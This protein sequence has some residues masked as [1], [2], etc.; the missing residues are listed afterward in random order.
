MRSWKWR[1]WTQLNMIQVQSA[2]RTMQAAAR[3]VLIRYCVARA[4][5]ASA[6]TLEEPSMNDKPLNPDHEH[7]PAYKSLDS[8]HTTTTDVDHPHSAV[9][10]KRL[11]TPILDMHGL[12][13]DASET[14]WNTSGRRRISSIDGPLPPLPGVYEYEA[15][16]QLHATPSPPV[17]SVYQNV[18]VVLP[19]QGEYGTYVPSEAR[20][21]GQALSLSRLSEI[22]V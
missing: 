2:T 14:S 20:L 13:L 3:S 19:V 12:P 7:P 5:H 17:S 11:M 4:T 18:D 8:P 16:S 10:R 6:Q 15:V 9:G 21:P 1:Q 22:E